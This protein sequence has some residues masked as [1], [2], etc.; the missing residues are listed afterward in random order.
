M[1]PEEKCQIV[2]ALR[3]LETLVV[4]LDRIGSYTAS[5]KNV[6]PGILDDFV[7][8][9]EVF[10]RA[11]EAREALC[12]FFCDEIADGEMQSEVELLLADVDLWEPPQS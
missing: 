4:S 5:A 8:R 2:T 6:I 12:S 9:H 11:A 1:S 10:R 7:D 3:F